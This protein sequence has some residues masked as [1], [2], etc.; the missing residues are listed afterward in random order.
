MSNYRINRPNNQSIYISIDFFFSKLKKENLKKKKKVSNDARK[1]IR[2]YGGESRDTHNLQKKQHESY[3]SLFG[4][5][6]F[7]PHN[8]KEKE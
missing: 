4:L 2:E 8:N 6:F 5:F 1:D 3:S 7:C